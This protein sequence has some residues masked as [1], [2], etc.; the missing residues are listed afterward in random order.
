LSVMLMRMQETDMS[1]EN[2]CDLV[3]EIANTLAGNARRD[4]GHQFQISVPAVLS[5][6]AS[7]V[8]YPDPSR[9][10]VIPIDWR[11]YHARLIVCL[12]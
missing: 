5:S 11:N 3:G 7:P 10:I 8:P 1:H 6:R 4:F 9:P 12:V 2:L